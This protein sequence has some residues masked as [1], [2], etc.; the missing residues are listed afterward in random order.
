MLSPSLEIWQI[1]RSYHYSLVMHCCFSPVS[2]DSCANG[3]LASIN[4]IQHVLANATD[5][6]RKFYVI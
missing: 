3:W 2:Q 1:E 5:H 6:P 4:C